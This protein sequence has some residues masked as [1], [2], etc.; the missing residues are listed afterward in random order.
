MTKITDMTAEQLAAEARRW[1][2]INEGGEGYNPARDEMA[3]RARIADAARPK[4]HAERMYALQRRLDAMD[5]SMARESGTYDA[6]ECETLREHI[7]NLQAEMDA[8]FIEA[9]SLETTRARRKANNDWVRRNQVKGKTHMPTYNA[10]L[11]SQ[12][13]STNDLA[14]AIKLHGIQAERA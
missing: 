13:W 6:N 10:W 7:A 3:R 12:G 2:G 8:E 11:K 1:N 9:W 4:S 5:N 14:R